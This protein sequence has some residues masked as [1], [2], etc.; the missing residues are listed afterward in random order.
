MN[1]KKILDLKKKIEIETKNRYKKME[2]GFVYV[3]RLGPRPSLA[4][5]VL[6]FTPSLFFPGTGRDNHLSESHSKN[7]NTT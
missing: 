6:C 5:T 4:H 7:D 1:H 2:F 3:C